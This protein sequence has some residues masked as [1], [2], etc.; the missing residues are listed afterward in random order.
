MQDYKNYRDYWCRQSLGK[1]LFPDML[2]SRP[3]NRALAGK[4][5]IIGGNAYGFAAPAEAFA[6]AEA[7]GIGV[8]RVALPDS[9]RKVIG[10]AF[11]AGEFMPGTP[12][13][14][15]GQRALAGI[16]DMAAW[17]DAALLAG[18][19]GR[20]SETA[21]L[22]EKFVAKYSGQLTVCDD[23]ADYFLAL[24]ELVIGR[25]DTLLV[26]DFNQAQKL[27]ITT[28]FPQALTSDMDF[29]RLVAALHDFTSQ[30]QTHLIIEH[31]NALFVAV[32]GQVSSSA[33]AAEGRKHML[34][35][36][37]AS[38]AVWWLQNS[39]KSFEALTTSLVET[40]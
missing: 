33:Q 9:L 19:M 21:I 38:A 11:A 5:L 18:D 3:E 6:A 2:W 1:P 10:T 12:S 31:Q 35:Q 30:H 28:R 26:L 13:G 16:L 22:L 34:N 24:H 39:G 4:L 8:A 40:D 37:A 27:F 17:S 14:S 23:A 29:I 36:I 25:P 20:N 32:N 7:A 15:F